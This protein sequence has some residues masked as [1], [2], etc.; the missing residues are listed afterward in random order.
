MTPV[1][2]EP[3]AIALLTYSTRPRGDVVHTLALADALAA[4]GQGVTVW[5]LARGGD[6][7][8]F[9]RVDPRVTLRMVP[10]D[11]VPDEPLDD[12]VTRSIEAMGA[13]F[14]RRGTDIVHAHDCI[15][16]NAVADCIRTVHHLDRFDTPA[17]VACH[18]RA[19]VRP[20]TL[21][22]GSAAVA[23]EVFAGWARTPTVVPSGVEAER[24][25]RAAARGPAAVMAREAW[26]KKFGRFVFTVG[27]IE[28][29]KGSID[30][31]HA[32]AALRRSAEDVKLVIAGGDTLFDYRDYRAEWEQ[33]AEELN[34]S[35]VVLGPVPHQDLPPL[36]AAA[37]VFAFP[38]INE[39]FGLAALEALAAGVPLVT[40]DLPVMKEVFGDAA[41]FA[42]TPAEFAG[43]LATALHERD[44]ERQAAGMT[45]ASTYTWKAAA[46][47]HLRL[48]RLVRSAA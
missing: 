26:R 12:R 41:R 14:D 36:M 47:A 48:Y 29:R 3:L 5:A 22:C 11:D 38:S 25:T 21:V 40:S 15:S 37:S 32:M 19:I 31:L 4:A 34:L 28:P 42:A 20:H 7:S 1:H 30:L 2:P 23:A 17:L 9:R 43:E 39:G 35:P 13:A 24:F 8:L 16:A 44:P 45:L 27:G 6:T 33:A 10:V 18:E 46:E